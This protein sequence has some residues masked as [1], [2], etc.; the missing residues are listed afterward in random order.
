VLHCEP[1]E[2]QDRKLGTRQINVF[3]SGGINTFSDAID[4]G[5]KMKG[6]NRIFRGLVNGV[7]KQNNQRSEVNAAPSNL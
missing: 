2:R 4:I 6:A 3:D 7:L 1:N 5:D